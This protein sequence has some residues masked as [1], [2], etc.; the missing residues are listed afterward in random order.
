MLA[1]KRSAGVAQAKKHASK[2]STL[3]LKFRTDVTKSP[4]QEYQ[5]PRKFFQKEENVSEILQKRCIRL[6]VL[7]N[8]LLSLFLV[9]SSV[10]FRRQNTHGKT[11]EN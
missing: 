5:W 11:S 4:K 1:D 8:G 2:E 6:S 10:R 7:F 3:A 9:T